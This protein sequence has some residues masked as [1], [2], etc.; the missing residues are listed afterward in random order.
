MFGGSAKQD[1]PLQAPVA[2]RTL[3]GTANQV[4]G[5][6][7]AQ[8]SVVFQ[9]L[10]RRLG[11]SGPTFAECRS[12]ILA[13]QAW[14]G[15]WAGKCMGG[16]ACVGCGLCM[17]PWSNHDNTTSTDSTDLKPRGGSEG[18]LSFQSSVSCRQRVTSPPPPL[19]TQSSHVGQAGQAAI[20]TFGCPSFGAFTLAKA[21]VRH[22]PSTYLGA[23]NGV[24]KTGRRAPQ[25]HQTRRSWKE[26]LARVGQEPAESVCL[27]RAT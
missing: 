22:T 2:S 17:V 23:T 4:V 3:L 19:P 9:M 15:R 1:G 11:G 20:F 8:A 18:V 24:I 16:V 10:G 26:A 7:T 13:E 6:T 12:S 5:S 14:T 21:T 25:R 27:R